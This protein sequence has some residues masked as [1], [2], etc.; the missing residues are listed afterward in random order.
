MR[1]LIIG[2][3]LLEITHQQLCRVGVLSLTIR[4]ELVELLAIQFFQQPVLEGAFQH[5]ATQIAAVVIQC[6]GQYAGRHLR[7]FTTGVASLATEAPKHGQ[8][9]NQQ[10]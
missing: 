4:Q 8:E 7:L 3:A 9:T 10:R 5:H 2:K 1:C 6:H